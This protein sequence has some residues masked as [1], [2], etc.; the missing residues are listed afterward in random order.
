MSILTSCLSRLNRPQLATFSLTLALVSA[1]LIPAIS[2]AQ[3]YTVR[4]LGVMPQ[5][6]QPYIIGGNLDNSGAAVGTIFRNY[7]PD[8]SSLRAVRWDTSGAP[9][10]LPLLHF[11]G[12]GLP[13]SD[14][15]NK[16]WAVSPNGRLIVGEEYAESPEDFGQ[17]PVVWRNGIGGRVP[18]PPGCPQA[19]ATGVN[20]DGT[21]SLIISA[22]SP[23]CA[24]SAIVRRG[25]ILLLPGNRTYAHAVGSKHVVGNTSI[26]SDPEYDRSAIRGFAFNLETQQMVIFPQ[27]IVKG[28]AS[29]AA[30][31]NPD[32]V[33][34][35]SITR[36]YYDDN[37]ESDELR[38][39]AAWKAS[40]GGMSLL[41]ELPGTTD[42]YAGSVN[43]R[44]Q[45]VGSLRTDGDSMAVLWSRGHVLDL[46]SAVPPG[47]PH[48]SYASSIN[49]SGQILAH[50]SDAG[51][52]VLTPAP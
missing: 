34:V 25:N 33:V 49:D 12:T 29:Y 20:D 21:I 11:A 51:P 50:T 31:V 52:V 7:I 39:A 47:T 3:Q 38:R 26:S 45:I 24:H 42:S 2:A 13:E 14:Y 10:L 15:H 23:S 28:G 17:R 18:T 41:P 8:Y 44:G 35:G 32:G 1:P 46:N 16:A 4:A 6:D 48:L 37:P 40:S 5:Q 22:T 19:S 43:R 30:A 36:G 27:V 9:V